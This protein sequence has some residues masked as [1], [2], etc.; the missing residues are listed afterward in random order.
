MY[1]SFMYLFQGGQRSARKVTSPEL[2]SSADTI[3]ELP[4]I[5][6]C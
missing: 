3:F 2:L 4:M 5:L 6:E 1:F